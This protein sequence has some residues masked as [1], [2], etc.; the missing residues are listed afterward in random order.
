ML[1]TGGEDVDVEMVDTGT[2]DVPELSVSTTK[3]DDG[4]EF[5]TEE[6]PEVGIRPRKCLRQGDIEYCPKL[7]SALPEAGGSSTAR[8]KTQG[9][10]AFQPDWSI[11]KDETVMG[12]PLVSQKLMMG[13]SLKHDQ[14]VVYSLT[15]L[16]MIS[17]SNTL[18][19]SLLDYEEDLKFQLNYTVK[20][21]NVAEEK[22]CKVEKERD[23]AQS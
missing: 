1:G 21:L 16:A 7:V 10:L 19:S 3:G 13:C 22:L 4:K 6:M 5:P 15:T 11:M 14:D 9:E 23:E 12:D 8:D 18:M 17:G 20:H 2:L